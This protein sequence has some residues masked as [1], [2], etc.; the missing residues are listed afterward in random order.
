MEFLNKIFR[1]LN[2]FTGPEEIV[3]TG[4]AIDAFLPGPVEAMDAAA[5]GLESVAFN[6]WTKA[7]GNGEKAPLSE[8]T[9]AVQ[10][11]LPNKMPAA[12]QK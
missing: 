2:P 11:D 5:G 10:G 12:R 8:D 7:S 6:L 3:R 9:A 1:I 4:D